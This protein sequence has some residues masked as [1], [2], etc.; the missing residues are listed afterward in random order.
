MACVGLAVAACGSA[1]QKPV[2]KSSTRT[3]QAVAFSKC[4]RGHGLTNFPDVV[5]GQGIPIQDE[6]DGSVA[7]LVG[8][9]PQP[10]SAPKLNVAL[11]AC[12]RYMIDLMASPVGSGL[13]PATIQHAAV[14]TAECFRRDGVPNYPDPP[15]LGTQQEVHMSPRARARSAGIDIASPAFV[16]A[17]KKCG[18]IL[19]NAMGR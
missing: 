6:L 1:S 3:A 18:S 13:T 17:S 5:L 16:A 9:V 14:Q 10:V 11:K 4:M 12:A 8:G 7:I 2:R 15:A 19:A